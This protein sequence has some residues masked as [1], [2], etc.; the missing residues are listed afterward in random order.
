[1][2]AE[3][4][5]QQGPQEAFL[6]RLLT[7]LFMAV[8]RAVVNPGRCCWNVPLRHKDNGQFSCVIFRRTYP[9]VTNPGGLWDESIKLYGR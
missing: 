6:L 8:R 7:L 2:A 4:R 3:F 5:P 1:M 9:Q